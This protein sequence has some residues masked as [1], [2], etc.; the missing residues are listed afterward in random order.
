MVPKNARP[1]NIN[2]KY[3][4]WYIHIIRNT[5]LLKVKTQN[6]KINQ[7]RLFRSDKISRGGSVAIF[8]RD[9]FVCTIIQITSDL[10]QLSLTIKINN[11][12]YVIGIRNRS[13]NT[14]FKELNRLTWRISNNGSMELSENI[15]LL[16]NINIDLSRNNSSSNYLS[17]IL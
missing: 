7:F 8:D 16:G 3:S 14:S 4:I 9:N 1:W 6:I 15:I 13:P 5:V 17:A 2:R 12:V 10:E 11:R